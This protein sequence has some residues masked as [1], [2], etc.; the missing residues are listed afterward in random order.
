MWKTIGKIAGYIRGSWER[1]APIIAAPKEEDALQAS[2][3]LLDELVEEKRQGPS[4]WDRNDL[5]RFLPDPLSDEVRAAL[6]QRGQEPPAVPTTGSERVRLRV[7][8][9]KRLHALAAKDS[10]TFHLPSMTGEP[11]FA[12]TDPALNELAQYWATNTFWNG[13]VTQRW[14][15]PPVFFGEEFA[16]KFFRELFLAKHKVVHELRT[17][18]A[19]SKSKDTFIEQQVESMRYAVIPGLHDFMQTLEEQLPSVAR[20]CPGTYWRALDSS[21]V[22]KIEEDAKRSVVKTAH[23]VISNVKLRNSDISVPELQK[24]LTM[25]YR[26]SVLEELNYHIDRLRKSGLL[27]PKPRGKLS[28]TASRSRF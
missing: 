10:K 11:G 26:D 7:E 9:A 21:L 13:N 6:V 15:Y 19:L 17:A 5:S 14:Y 8:T 24:T 3:R 18:A 25:F 16:A 28:R 4:P 22:L 2:H 20:T 1:D 23:I 12:E 27:K